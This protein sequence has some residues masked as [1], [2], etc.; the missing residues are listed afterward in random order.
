MINA[1]GQVRLATRMALPRIEWLGRFFYPLSA[2]VAEILKQDS[3]D[4]DAGRVN[5][6]SE[7]T[8]SEMEGTDLRSMWVVIERRIP[9][10]TTPRCRKPPTPRK[11]K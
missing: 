9:W 3:E 2:R 10:H 1:R 6:L 7:I 8:V 4:Y 11:P 5:A